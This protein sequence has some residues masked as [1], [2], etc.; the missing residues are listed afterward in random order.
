MSWPAISPGGGR[1]SYVVGILIACCT[2]LV[3]SQA[4]DHQFL[5]FDDDVYVTANQ[6]IREGFTGNSIYWALTSLTG[7]NWHPL[8]WFSHIIDYKLYGLNPAGHHATNIVVHTASSLLL[9]VFLTRTTGSI[10]QS[11]FVAAV[12][13]LHPLHVESVAWIAERKDVLC[14]FFWFASLIFYSRYSERG[15]TTAYAAALSMYALALMSKPMAVSLPVVM[16]ALDHW[17]LKR[18]EFAGDGVSKCIVWKRVTGLIV[19]KLPFLAL[20]FLSSI[21]TI[22]A[23]QQ[24]GAVGQLQY[25]PLTLRFEN[26]LVSYVSYLLK[27]LWPVGLA[28]LYPFPRSIPVWQVLGSLVV[29]SLF[30]LLVLR[31]VLTHRYLATG[32]LWYLVTLLPVIGII[33]VGSQAMADRYMYLP[34]TGLLIMVAW[35]APYLSGESCS[36]RVFCCGAGILL[37][38]GY[39]VMTWHQLALWRNSVQLYRQ[40][41]AVTEENHLVHYNL[42]IEYQKQGLL[43]EAAEEYKKALLIQTDS[44][45]TLTNLGL[46]YAARG[47]MRDA[48]TT[49]LHIQRIDPEYA[50]ARNNLGVVLSRMGDY[51]AAI[52]EF[53]EVLRINANDPEAHYNLG[54][55]FTAQ[56]KPDSAIVEYQASLAVNPE[57]DKA[58]NNLGIVFV[59]K[60]DLDSAIGEFER[61]LRINPDNSGAAA[62]LEKTR[63]RKNGSN[64]IEQESSR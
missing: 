42:G 22:Y 30:L 50:P 32:W 18:F 17:P 47:D 34:L 10:W 14:A 63:V 21:V 12:F 13:A 43:D 64:S 52:T 61:A 29:I 5:S 62:N 39:A 60:D 45:K 11:S 28:V 46:V 9:L 16:L 1:L 23:Q 49:F 25:L 48:I 3:Y 58:H 40:T 4:L 35:G 27:T 44:I 51:D 20:A 56:G 26:A 53:R 36:R 2:L 55:I 7:G 6:H 31:T 59:M 41:L 8:T 37:V 24:A 57:N 38:A 33:Q 19:E 15:S 54:L